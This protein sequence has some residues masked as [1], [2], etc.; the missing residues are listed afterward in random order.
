[1]PRAAFHRGLRRVARLM[2]AGLHIGWGAVRVWRSSLAARLSLTIAALLVVV[3]L[4]TVAVADYGLRL[5]AR[6][7]AERDL[8]AAAVLFDR[9][10]G[11]EAED[12]RAQAQVVARDFGFREAV[13]LGDQRTLASALA[14][15]ADRTHA[16][17]AYVIALDGTAT[18]SPGSPAIDPRTLHQALESGTTGGMLRNPGGLAL[19]VA[20]PIELPDLAG[21]LVLTRRIDAATMDRLTNLSGLPVAAEA[22]GADRLDSDLARLNGAGIAQ[23]AGAGGD[24]LVRVSPM[25]SLDA[26]LQPRLVLRYRL[27]AAS[28]AYANL[29]T[30]LACIALFAVAFGVALAARLARGILTPLDRLARATAALARGDMVRVDA[31]GSDEMATLGRGFNAMVAAIAEREQ[32]ITHAWLHD[33]LTNLPNRRFFKEKLDQALAGRGADARVVVALLDLDDFKLVNDTLGQ[34][35]GDAL[36]LQ[37]AA[38]LQA[39]LPQA[40]IARFGNDEFGVMI[41]QLPPGRDLPMLIETIV[42][43]VSGEVAIEDR[44]VPLS[45]AIGVAVCPDDAADSDALLN[46]AELAQQRAKLDGKGIYHFFEATLDE[47]AS[48]RRRIAIDLREAL[49]G[50]EFSLNFQPLYSPAQRTIKGFEALLRWDHPQRGRISPADFIPVAEQSGLIIPIS[51][52]VIREACLQAAQWDDD[53]AVAVNISPSHFRVPGLVACVVGALAQSQ[54]APHRLELEIT[55]GVFISNF[56]ATLATLRQLRALGVRIA[57]DDFGTGYSSLSYLRAFPFDKVKIDQSFVRDLANDASA[58]AVVRAITALA[59][60]LGMETLAEGVE[61]VAQYDALIAEGCGMIQG[62]LISRP[63]PIADIAGVLARHGQ[64]SAATMRVAGTN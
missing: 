63:V 38:R 41:T 20:A 29:R 54:L 13:G 10:L 59:A 45:A 58:R 9:N 27:A 5:Y 42:R 6:S 8:V 30:A 1:M 2:P 12:L 18:A 16:A 44:Q 3:M 22:A 25:A 37:C 32:R 49:P 17:G 43:Q 36:L 34:A 26:R 28:A 31:A 61:D 47:E 35:A 60:A 52:W 62:Y 57:L 53:L 14:S 50:G 21:W 4:A 48:R 11:A 51:E 56:E 24:E 46:Q 55:E 15:L 33:A 19:G 7:A 64:A 39:C 23:R 40:D